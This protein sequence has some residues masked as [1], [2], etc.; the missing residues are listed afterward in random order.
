MRPVD[1][2]NHDIY[3]S[4]TREGKISFLTNTAVSQL[5]MPGKNTHS[6]I[7]MINEG[8]IKTYNHLYKSMND[9]KNE[10]ATRKFISF[11]KVN[12]INDRFILL[13]C[14]EAGVLEA[15]NISKDEFIKNFILP[16]NNSGKALPVVKGEVISQEAF[17]KIV[18]Q[19]R[20]QNPPT[21]TVVDTVAKEIDLNG[22]VNYV[23]GDNNTVIDYYKNTLLSAINFQEN[24][25]L[26]ISHM[27]NLVDMLNSAV[28]KQTMNNMLMVPN[29]KGPDF[30]EL[31]NYPF[32]KTKY[33]LCLTARTTDKR[34]NIV[35]CINT[36][37]ITSMSVFTADRK[38]C[39]KSR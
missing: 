1:N 9:N 36:A 12:K 27:K 11:N 6:P 19:N 24:I 3:E 2:F 4:K 18:N 14:I 28:F 34:R 32:D 16:D 22:Q 31:R 37:D 10:E 25:A 7:S 15:L 5:D 33:N 26:P 30:T 23:D 35:I 13:S 38:V 39:N 29:E 17:N 20:L 21:N 8:D